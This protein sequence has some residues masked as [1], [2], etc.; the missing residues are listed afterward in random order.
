[1]STIS[2][3]YQSVYASNLPAL[4]AVGDSFDLPVYYDASDPQL[5]GLTLNIHFDSSLLGLLFYESKVAD[6]F[7]TPVLLMTA[8]I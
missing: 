7:G 3:N 6:L 2:L 8:M 1:M 5:T 4:L